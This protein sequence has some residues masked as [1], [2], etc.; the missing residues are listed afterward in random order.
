MKVYKLDK[1]SV[2][3]LKK[4]IHRKNWNSV[5]WVNAGNPLEK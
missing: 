4:K 2:L 3:T 5:T 1:M